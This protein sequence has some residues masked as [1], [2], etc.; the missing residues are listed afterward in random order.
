MKHPADAGNQPSIRAGI[1]FSE[2]QGDIQGRQMLA[3]LTK[4]VGELQREE[5]RRFR[6][7]LSSD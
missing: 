2:L 4:I 5:I 6:M 3:Q 7:G 1:Q